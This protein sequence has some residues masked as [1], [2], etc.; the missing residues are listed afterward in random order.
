[1]RPLQHQGA[2]LVHES[3]SP[4]PKCS[5]CLSYPP[6]PQLERV[7]N[8][9]LLRSIGQALAKCPMEVQKGTM[10]VPRN[11]F[12]CDRLPKSVCRARLGDVALRHRGERSAFHVVHMDKHI[13]HFR[14]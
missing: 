10:K 1:M 13:L 6:P 3:L 7:C 12:V 2:P 5:L 11:D 8:M 4:T 9:S 14:T